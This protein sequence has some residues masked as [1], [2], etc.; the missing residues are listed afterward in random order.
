MST[1][2]G[3][4]PASPAQITAL[5]AKISRLTEEVN[6]YQKQE[7]AFE[8]LVALI[9]HE[10]RTPIGALTAMCEL[11]GN[12]DLN[13]IQ[14]HYI[15]TLK[16]AAETLSN[17]TKDMTYFAEIKS[18]QL[19]F[20]PRL[21]N[22]SAFMSS[23]ALS[24]APQA[25]ARGLKFRAE[26]CRDVP[27]FIE[28]DPH[29]LNQ[30]ITNLTNN[31]LKYT[32]AGEIA[33]SVAAEP[34]G[35]EAYELLIE[36][37]DTGIGLSPED[38]ARIFTP[39]YQTDKARQLTSEGSGLGLWICRQIA[40]GFKGELT[41]QSEEGKG[42]AFILK[43]TVR[44]SEQD[45]QHQQDIETALSMQQAAPALN[46]SLAPWSDEQSPVPAPQQDGDCAPE[47]AEQLQGQPPQTP[48]RLA[49]HVLIVDDNQ[50]N[51]ML[52]RMHLDELG[53]THDTA[54]NGEEAL[55]AIRACHYDVILLDMRMP[56]LDGI[57]TAA[58]MHNFWQGERHTAIIAVS[59]G[60]NQARQADYAEAGIDCFI[61]KPINAAD[62]YNKLALYLPFAGHAPMPEASGESG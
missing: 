38:Q 44:G 33:L 23:I 55:A 27:P 57:A 14:A 6:A 46:E 18:G 16:F 26:M 11:L 47:S 31:A 28:V 48:L 36:V 58:A 9:S 40:A 29:R 43:L 8:A 7:R 24:I 54:N 56:G 32:E 60:D 10:V 19:R 61:D 62:L 49:G 22:F 5:Q 45:E 12:T 42:S 52:I 30:I 34:L 39:F 1:E 15:K 4:T 53:L 13:D 37:E 41:C 35:G 3:E 50:I 21:I 25:E 51:Q 17:T 20:E 59:A 2:H